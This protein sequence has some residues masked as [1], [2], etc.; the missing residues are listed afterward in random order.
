MQAEYAFSHHQSKEYNRGGEGAYKSI[1]KKTKL[2][3]P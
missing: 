3:E 2:K 1:E